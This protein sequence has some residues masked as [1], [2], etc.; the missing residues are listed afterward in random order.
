MESKCRDLGIGIFSPTLLPIADKDYTLKN[1][2]VIKIGQHFLNWGQVRATRDDYHAMGAN[3][4]KA[5]GST[6]QAIF[7]TE[8][9]D[10]FDV[11]VIKCAL[12]AKGTKEDNLKAVY[13]R[14][15]SHFLRS[16]KKMGG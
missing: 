2:Q 16:Q 14:S 6:T 13:L 1:G 10:A 15:T 11:D 3:S 9:F 8:L 5:R 7:V 4:A 12:T